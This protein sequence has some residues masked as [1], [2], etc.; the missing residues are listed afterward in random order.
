MTK[1]EKYQNLEK[2]VNFIQELDKLKSVY[3]RG[4]IKYDDNRRENTAEHSWHV[5]LTG[6][7][8]QEYARGDIDV[9][10]VLKMLLIHDLVEI[11]AGDTYAFDNHEILAQQNIKELEA[12]EKVF[13]L[14][15]ESE[16]KEYKMLWLEFEEGD[17]LE[18]K[19]SKAIDR[20]VPVFQNMQNNGGS[21]TAY[22]KVPKEKVVKR[23]IGLKYIAPELWQYVEN[24]L[25]I[26]WQRG[27]LV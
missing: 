11:Y 1:S 4:L 9:L 3:R 19:F 21:W 14:L 24:Q 8:L 6:I 27:W 13:S 20:V 2:K 16:A 26:A 18:A 25:D 12:L 10:K 22:G 23:N 15:P 7:I 17:T 5:A